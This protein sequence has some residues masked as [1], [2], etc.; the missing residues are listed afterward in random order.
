MK[1]A[2]IS[3]LHANVPALESVLAEASRRRVD[4]V[5]CLGD[6]VDLGPEPVRVV[7][8]LRERNID[9]LQGNHDPPE[10]VPTEP[11]AVWE[12]TQLQLGDAERAWLSALPSRL[13][14]RF[15]GVSLACV[16]GSP[17]SFDE[18]ILP[19]TPDEELREILADETSDVLVCGHTH[20]QLERRLG[21]R[22]IVN[23]GSVGMPFE[24]PLL[25]PGVPRIHPWAEFAV[26][27]LESGRASAE[28]LRI[29]YDVEEYFRRVL[30]STMPDPANF[31]S[32]WLPR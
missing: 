26:L 9:T 6:V 5:V 30:A 16:H 3:D 27:T 1:L 18:Q 17:R 19:L 20:V 2:L 25:E 14:Y 8:M 10:G 13:D 11:R 28:L 4:R 22:L 32:A 7:E 21:E 31:I 15:E 12:W 23:V 29:D 24:E